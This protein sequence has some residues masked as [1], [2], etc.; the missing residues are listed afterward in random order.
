MDEQAMNI[1]EGLIEGRNVF[2]A[3]TLNQM[4]PGGRDSAYSR[5]LL[6]ELCYLEVLSRVFSYGVRNASQ[7]NNPSIVLNIPSTF[8]ES[9]PV[10]A[11]AEQINHSVEAIPNATG[12]CAICQDAITTNAARIRHCGHIYHRNCLV[13]WLSM[14]VRC[15]QCRHDI[16]EGLVNQTSADNEEMSPLTPSQ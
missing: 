12:D 7:T 10:V 15:P 11:T 14:S 9:V 16:R 8:L 6:N 4:R 3:R 13:T 1:L 2:F 5:Y